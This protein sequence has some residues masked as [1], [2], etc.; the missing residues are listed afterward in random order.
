MGFPKGE[1]AHALAAGV[2]KNVQTVTLVVGCAV[3]YV[4]ASLIP[5]FNFRR[6]FFAPMLWKRQIW[7]PEHFEMV[8]PGE[9]LLDRVDIET[10]A[11]RFESFMRQFGTWLPPQGAA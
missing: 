2:S 11:G 8:W 3:F 9:R 6:R 7:P 10:L 5:K 4:S 1:E